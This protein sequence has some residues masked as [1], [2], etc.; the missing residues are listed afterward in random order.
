M[1]IGLCGLIGSGKGTVADILVNEY[2]FTKI[3]FADSLKNGIATIFDWDRSLLEG[4]TK[5]SREWRETIDPFWTNEV[6]FNVTPRLVLQLFGTECM[7]NGF[8]DNIWVSVVKKKITDN[9]NTNYVI[10][11][12][13]FV[14]E[15]DMIRSLGGWIWEV[16]RDPL[17]KW[18]VEY[19]R[20]GVPPTDV[21]RSE[22]DWALSYMNVIIRN[23]A[24][25]A[26]LKK[27]VDTYINIMY[28]T[29]SK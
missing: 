15:I 14:N 11:D 17:P 8:H 24:D 26:W 5:E 25:I 2:D 6:G 3:S 1:L 20:T 23:E 19:R 9:P 21:H 22:W 13:R 28:D 27:M 12:T 18:F 29:K 10:P 7:R 4:D 16:N